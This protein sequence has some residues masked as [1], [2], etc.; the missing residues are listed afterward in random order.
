M[1]LVIYLY[2]V[3]LKFFI[4]RQLLLS[5]YRTAWLVESFQLGHM[6]EVRPHSPL[7]T[8]APRHRLK[9]FSIHYLAKTKEKG[10]LL[11]TTVASVLLLRVRLSR[12]YTNVKHVVLVIFVCFLVQ[13]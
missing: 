3:D 5:K 13:Y 10:S 9:E 12:A 1:Q 2:I 11:S 6:L 4:R 8:P 7:L